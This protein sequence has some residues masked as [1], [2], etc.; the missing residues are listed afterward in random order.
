MNKENTAERVGSAAGL[1]F[2]V[3]AAGA[4]IGTCA[5]SFVQLAETLA[6]RKKR[7]RNEGR[8]F[9]VPVRPTGPQKSSKPPLRPVPKK[10]SKE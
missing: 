1:I 10:D 3:A 9:K 6:E 8:V 7:K 5:R 4:M 2:L